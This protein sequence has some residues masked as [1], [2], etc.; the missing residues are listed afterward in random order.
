[1][2]GQA[3]AA[4][5]VVARPGGLAGAAELDR[6]PGSA[7]HEYRPAPVGVSQRRVQQF[8]LLAG[9]ASFGEMTEETRIALMNYDWMIRNRG[10]DYAELCWDS[11]KLVYGGDTGDI[12][13]LCHFGFTPATTSEGL[14]ALFEPTGDDPYGF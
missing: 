1:V 10:L 8:P 2:T 7:Q 6:P 12:D 13:Y 14:R 11:G 3:R 5:P 9:H 4:L